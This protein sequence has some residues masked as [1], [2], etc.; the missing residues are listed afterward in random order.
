M[1][2]TGSVSVIYQSLESPSG[3]VLVQKE[4][5]L[6]V[7]KILKRAGVQNAEEVAWRIFRRESG[8]TLNLRL[9]KEEDIF[10][11]QTTTEMADWSA[12]DETTTIK[13]NTLLITR[14]VFCRAY[15]HYLT[16]QPKA[17]HCRLLHSLCG[18]GRESNK[19]GTGRIGAS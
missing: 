16:L 7:W 13:R 19:Q 1:T 12:S 4:L 9:M 15:V 11:F 5:W 3:V 10:E 18:G 6:H 14:L 17:D 2:G 8:E